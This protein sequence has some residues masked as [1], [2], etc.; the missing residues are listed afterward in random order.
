MVAGIIPHN[1]GVRSP[2]FI[3]VV[4]RLDEFLQEQPHSIIIRVGLKDTS[5]NLPIRVKSYD[6]SD[7]RLD[8]FDRDAVARSF[9]LPTCTSIVSRVYPTLIDVNDAFLNL[10]QRE[11]RDDTLLPLD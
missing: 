1:D 9:S 2:V 7:P 3:L 5:V 8:L 11:K 4:E 6:Q 10:D